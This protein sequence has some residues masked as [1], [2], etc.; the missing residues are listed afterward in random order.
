MHI[1]NVGKGAAVNVRVGFNRLGTNVESKEYVE[2]ITLKVGDQL[3]VGV[4]GEN[5]LKGST[6][7]GQYCLEFLYYDIFGNKYE[8]KYDVYINNED[9]YPSCKMST[10]QEQVVLERKNRN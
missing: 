4:F 3:T 9:G 5:L 6:A 2:P 8:Q 10:L 1:E 7:L